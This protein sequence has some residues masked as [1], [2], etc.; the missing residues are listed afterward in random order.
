MWP[1][2]A[3]KYMAIIIAI[4]QS[5]DIFTV[6]GPGIKPGRTKHIVTQDLQLGNASAK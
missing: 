3:L 5:R 1:E 2:P 4:A 6:A